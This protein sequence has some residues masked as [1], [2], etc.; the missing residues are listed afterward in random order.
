M[1]ESVEV[2]DDPVEGLY[3]TEKRLTVAEVPGLRVR[4]LKLTSGQCVPWHHH[5]E[6]KDTFFCMQGPM[7]IKTRGP[8]ALTLLHPGETAEVPPGRQHYV[9]GVKGGSCEFMI[10]QGVGTY[11]YIPSVD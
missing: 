4:Q 6:I 3:N 8:D 7:W 2:D 5:S 1:T 11:D 10:V 9:S